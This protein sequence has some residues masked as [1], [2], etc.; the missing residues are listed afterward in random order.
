VI[1]EVLHNYK[2]ME[3]EVN[4]CQK[5]L[6]QSMLVYR[7]IHFRDP[8]IDLDVGVQGRDKELVKPLLQLFYRADAQM[9]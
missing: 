7:L 4:P 8:I 1:F 3:I 2:K 6:K 9:K 5:V